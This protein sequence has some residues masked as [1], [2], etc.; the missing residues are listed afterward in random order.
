LEKKI[1]KLAKNQKKKETPFSK[2]DQETLEL[3]EIFNLK[4]ILL[5]L[6]NGQDTLLYKDRREFY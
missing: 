4:E 5:D 6:L 3:V 1:K 2:K